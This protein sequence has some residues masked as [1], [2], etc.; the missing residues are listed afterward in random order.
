L[1]EE[2]EAGGFEVQSRYADVAGAPFDRTAT[3]FAV[4]GKKQW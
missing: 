1:E 2:F 3:E 4:V